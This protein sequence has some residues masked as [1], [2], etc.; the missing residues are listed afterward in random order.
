MARKRKTAAPT[1]ARLYSLTQ[2]Q[3]RW[4]T[5]ARDTDGGVYVGVTAGSA[6]FALVDGGAAT[7]REVRQCSGTRGVHDPRP[8][9]W[10]DFYLVPTELGL[11][12]LRASRR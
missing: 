7:Y 12:L 6:V 1:A 2:E 11:E 4:L 10:T 9:E 8:C 3:A 5:D